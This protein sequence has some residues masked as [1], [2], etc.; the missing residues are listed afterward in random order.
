MPI[1]PEAFAYHPGLRD[2]ITDPATSFFRDF[3][4][5]RLEEM[6]SS[7]GLPTGW[8]YSDD[9]REKLRAK[10]LSTRPTGDLWVFGYGSLMWDPAFIFSQVRRGTLPG[11]M[12][13]FIL[14]DAK[15]GRGMP[16]APGLMAA[17]DTAPPEAVCDGLLFRIPEALV[18]TET[19]NLWCREGLSETYSA[20]FVDAHIDGMPVSALTFLANHEAEQIVP[21]ISR[22]EQVHLLATGRGFLGSSIDYLRNIQAQFSLLDVNDLEITSLLRDT[23]AYLAR[24]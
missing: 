12:R 19:A 7:R 23:E 6:I 9:E 11:H 20:A 21:H 2:K 22:D 1:D 24:L 13:R 18:E 17:L 8:W 4:L 3:S 16:E 5:A 15:G 14:R 10:V